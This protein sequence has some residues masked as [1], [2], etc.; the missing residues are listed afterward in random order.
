SR[1]RICSR[2]SRTRRGV[3]GGGGGGAAAPGGGGGAP[4]AP[5]GP[6]PPRGGPPGPRGAP[7]AAG[8]G[9]GPPPHPPAPPTPP[10][11]APHAPRRPPAHRLTQALEDDDGPLRAAVA[12]F[13]DRLILRRLV[14]AARF[15]LIR[16]A[17]HDRSRVGPLALD[18]AGRVRDGEQLTLVLR[19]DVEE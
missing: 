13:G 9:R 19:E 1:R 3:G 6:R 7:G 18:D 15:V 11:P 2:T 14:P 4:R 5:P 10:P 16:E 17:D 8:A 12:M